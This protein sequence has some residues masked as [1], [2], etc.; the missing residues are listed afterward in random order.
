[1]SKFTTGSLTKNMKEILP[2]DV[3][4]IYYA[5]DG[6]VRFADDAGAILKTLT[7]EDPKWALIQRVLVLSVSAQLWDATGYNKYGIIYKRLN[8]VQKE[9]VVQNDSVNTDSIS[10]DTVS[11]DSN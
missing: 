6:T 8:R 11:T 4:I 9:E 2:N 10:T 3:N 1:M 5:D 7:K